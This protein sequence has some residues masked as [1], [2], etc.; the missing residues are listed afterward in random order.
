MRPLTKAVFPVAGL[1]TR[2]LPATKAQP[3]EML[4]VIDKPL[5]QF[6]V[7]EA[8]D[9]GITQ[10]I[11]VIGRTKRSIA[12][13]F[14]SNPELD[15]LLRSKG[16]NEMADY[17][18]SIVPPHVTCI[19]FRQ[20]EALGLGHAVACA[21]PIIEP[22]E[23]FAVLLAD[24]LMDGEVPILSQMARLH[25]RTGRSVLAVEQVRPDEVS[26]YGIVDA[27]VPPRGGS[28]VVRAIVEKP[29]I[30]DAPS[31]LAVAGRYI[32]DGRIMQ[33]LRTQ[34][35]GSG[36]EVQLTDA[37]RTLI[38]MGGVD[39]YQFEGRRYDCGSKIGFIEAT[40]AHALVHPE[41]GPEVKRLMLELLERSGQSTGH[42]TGEFTG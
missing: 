9:A 7:E 6:A 36:G 5:I 25:A 26:S 22:D 40:M 32:L 34:K 30:K 24:D 13:H 4:T 23:H 3:K 29:S 20:A 37:I 33:T 12:D 41:F 39:A 21:A 38:P 18:N 10:L 1:G 14:D 17:L 28:S 35:A 19:Y 11:F 15:T 8:V 42:L 2:F 31:N 27:D 16:K